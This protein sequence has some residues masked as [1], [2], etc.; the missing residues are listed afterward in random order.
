MVSISDL[1]HLGNLCLD[2]YSELDHIN[3]ALKVFDDI[4][5]KNSTS[6]NICLKGLLKNSQHGKARHLF[7]EMPVGDVVS[8]NSMVSTLFFLWVFLV[9]P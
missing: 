5:Y 2:I 8:W 3:D 1:Q 7:D 9:M 6:W 4:S